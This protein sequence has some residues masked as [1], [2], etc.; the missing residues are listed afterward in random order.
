MPVSET[1]KHDF[2]VRKFKVTDVSSRRVSNRDVPLIR[3]FARLRTSHT[4]ST[5]DKS[6][7]AP[8]AWSLRYVSK[9]NWCVRARGADITIV[10]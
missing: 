8:L 2:P 1:E 3:A 9:P 10:K 7:I 5:V 4:G 6:D